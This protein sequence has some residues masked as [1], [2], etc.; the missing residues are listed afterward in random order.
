MRATSKLLVLPLLAAVM[1]V[2][3]AAEIPFQ[4][5]TVRETPAGCHQHNRRAPA[6]GPASHRCC[7]IG[8]QSAILPQDVRVARAPALLCLFR[9]AEFAAP[10][11]VAGEPQSFRG[12][13]NLSLALPVPAPLRL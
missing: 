3:L 13:L 11:S 9:T 8:H 1:A 10:P 4:A 7:Q 2:T 12:L 6:P 5:E